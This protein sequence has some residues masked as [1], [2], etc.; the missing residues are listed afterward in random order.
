M[1]VVCRRQTAHACLRGVPEFLDIIPILRIPGLPASSWYVRCGYPLSACLLIWD[2]QDH[3]VIPY[4]RAV[5]L[6]FLLVVYSVQTLP[7]ACLT[8][9][10]HTAPKLIVLRALPLGNDDIF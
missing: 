8:F 4:Q 1:F 6:Y 2:F 7:V 10:S 3:D 9:L 5:W